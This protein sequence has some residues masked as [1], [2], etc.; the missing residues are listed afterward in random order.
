[1]AFA[2]QL[3]ESLDRRQDQLEQEFA[4]GADLG[5]ILSRHLAAVE[6]AADSELLTSI[7]LLDDDGKRLRHAAAPMLPRSYCDAIDGAEIG[8]AAGSCGTAAV[9]GHPIYVVDIETDPLWADYREIALEHGLRACWST[10]IFD[11]EH[12]LLGTFA[13]YHRTPRSPTP[14]EVKAIAMIGDRV[15]EAIALSRSRGKQPDPLREHDRA[16]MLGELRTVRDL[17]DE[18]ARSLRELTAKDDPAAI[19]DGLCAVE[20]DCRNILAVLRDWNGRQN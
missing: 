18:N 2:L 12:A 20:R 5:T 10:P 15:A 1:M 9:V 11:A 6:G 7:L 4:A 16:P 19:F 14:A 13:I 3:R 17:L 8:P